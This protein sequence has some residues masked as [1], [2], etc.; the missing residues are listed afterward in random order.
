M[1]AEHADTVAALWFEPLGVVDSTTGS[2]GEAWT[3]SL[4][5][6]IERLPAA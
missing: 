6:R 3:A 1:S 5:E 4:R 2:R